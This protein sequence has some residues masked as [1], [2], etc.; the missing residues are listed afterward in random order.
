M[1]MPLPTASRCYPGCMCRS[2]FDSKAV[3]FAIRPMC[4]KRGL[5][6]SGGECGPV[7][8]MWC[9]FIEQAG[10]DESIPFF[11]PC[12]KKKPGSF[13]HPAYV[14]HLIAYACATVA[15]RRP[16]TTATQIHRMPSSL[17]RASSAASSVKVSGSVWP[18]TLALIVPL[19]NLIATSACRG[20]SCASPIST[21]CRNSGMC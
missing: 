6:A 8:A 2:Y 17:A 21:N 18:G 12:K 11:L 10:V 13:H 7:C 4:H 16:S 14:Q 5:R 3:Y 9:F 15:P 19:M 20:G 1:V